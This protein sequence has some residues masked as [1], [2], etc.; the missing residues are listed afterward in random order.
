ME[1]QKQK[2][3]GE[4]SFTRFVLMLKSVETSST[5]TSSA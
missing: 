5:D 3:P 4:A 1:I 2:K